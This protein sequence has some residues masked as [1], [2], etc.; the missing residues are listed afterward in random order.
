MSSRIIASLVAAGLVA[1]V[2]SECTCGASCVSTDGSSG[3]CGADGET[4]GQWITPP[5]CG[6]TTPALAVECDMYVE[7][8]YGKGDDLSA[9]CGNGRD[10]SGA[11]AQM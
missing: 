11:C 2:Q 1:A 8:L 7:T 3:T 6:T 4:C 5:D 10:E 9:L